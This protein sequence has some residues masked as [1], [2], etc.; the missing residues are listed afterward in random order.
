MAR[1]IISASRSQG[2]SLRT[3]RR[4]CYF[5]GR[6]PP[7]GRDCLAGA[8]GFL[9]GAG[10]DAEGFPDDGRAAEGFFADGTCDCFADLPTGAGR[11]AECF[12]WLL[13]PDGG[14]AEE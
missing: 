7:A 13:A 14:R 8:E 1:G 4:K 11:A 12:P 6:A 2:K 3:V 5:L 9:D 10:R